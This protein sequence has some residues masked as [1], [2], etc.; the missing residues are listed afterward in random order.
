MQKSRMERY[1]KMRE[2]STLD[3]LNSTPRSNARLGTS[4][5]RSPKTQPKRSA[6]K[7]AQRPQSL[8]ETTPTKTTP[9]KRT[10]TKS[11]KNA[12]RF[13]V[14]GTM[15]NRFSRTPK[16]NAA[17]SDEMPADLE[18][19]SLPV[20][21]PVTMQPGPDEL[22]SE[23]EWTMDDFAA[24]TDVA[25]HTLVRNT[26]LKAEFGLELTGAGTAEELHNFGRG[27]YVRSVADDL[28]GAVQETAQ[29]GMGRRVLEINGSFVGGA[30]CIQAQELMRNGGPQ[31]VLKTMAA[32]QRYDRFVVT[33]SNFQ[34]KT[35]R[36]SAESELAH[37]VPRGLWQRG[38]S[39]PTGGTD[40]ESEYTSDSSDYSS[41]DGDGLHKDYL[42]VGATANGRAPLQAARHA[43]VPL[44]AARQAPVPLQAARQAPEPSVSVGDAPLEAER[45]A[46]EP[47][48]R[49]QELVFRLDISLPPA[50]DEDL[51]EPVFPKS[52][53]PEV[54]V[55]IREEIIIRRESARQVQLVEAQTIFAQQARGV[56]TS[57][58]NAGTSGDPASEVPA[59]HHAIL[60]LK[61]LI[62][63]ASS[64]FLRLQEQDEPAAG[65]P[66]D[67]TDDI[68]EWQVVLSAKEDVCNTLK[69]AEVA[70]ELSRAVE[71][72]KLAEAEAAR[73][74][75]EAEA[76]IAAE[77]EAA[78]IAVMAEATAIAAEGDEATAAANVQA[79]AHSTN[80]FEDSGDSNN[81]FET[82]VDSSNPFAADAAADEFAA[83]TVNTDAGR[84]S[85]LSP[86]RPAPTSPMR[87]SEQSLVSA[88][89]GIERGWTFED[90]CANMEMKTVTI[91][92]SLFRLLSVGRGRRPKMNSCI[93]LGAVTHASQ[94]ARRCCRMSV[95]YPSLVAHALFIPLELLVCCTWSTIPASARCPTRWALGTF[96]L[97][98]V[99]AVRH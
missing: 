10:P 43:P 15:R 33:R 38:A 29:L 20:A 9:N 82:L 39:A 95:I 64:Y 36:S 7:S 86:T 23:D 78:V 51:G 85:E 99:K 52:G 65:T 35:R 4:P 63:I 49:L 83:K 26:E 41:I 70:L 17:A 57:V 5:K 87:P 80:P 91:G 34:K 13:S 8:L 48:A 56:V 32:H 62:E 19:L 24:N 88:A 98:G 69:A 40:S 14:L 22:I 44:R 27:V 75:A 16:K 79:P 11:A 97:A 21:E 72:Q 61:A 89:L 3:R 31:A 37:A 46:P 12:N 45:Q 81:P 74:A 77:A 18:N 53:V 71:A 66:G 94:C 42:A 55:R 25:T 59:L 6:Q 90:Y 68:K 84:S 1:L 28:F 30:T 96:I 92:K 47:P 76:A 93:G 73:K 67:L 58:I 2:T 50:F 54:D 60:T